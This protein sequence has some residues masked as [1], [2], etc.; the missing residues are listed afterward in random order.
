VEVPFAVVLIERVQS[1]IKLSRAGNQDGSVC[2]GFV[3]VLLGAR[4]DP[5]GLEAGFVIDAEGWGEG[6]FEAKGFLVDTCDEGEGDVGFLDTEAE[7]FLVDTCDEGEGDVGF[8]DTE[9]EGDPGF[10]E[11]TE[12]GEDP[13]VDIETG[14][15]P[16]ADSKPR[17][18]PDSV[19]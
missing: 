5:G 17:E 2:A 10:L 12:A 8:L 13:V 3:A 14:E 9:A 6:F 18:G 15:D 1:G 16:V 19:L 7:G 4:G 11:D